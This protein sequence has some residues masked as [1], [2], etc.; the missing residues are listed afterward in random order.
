MI[1]F[2]KQCTGIRS[3]RTLFY[4]S[5]FCVA[6]SVMRIILTRTIFL[7]FLAWNLAL[8]FIPWCIAITLDI[9]KLRNKWYAVCL[10]MLWLLF[11]PNA[12]YILTD[13]I[14][15]KKT[16]SRYDWF[17]FILI[18]SYCFTGLFYGYVSLDFIERAIS[19]IFKMKHTLWFVCAVL[20]LSAYGIYLGR[21]LRWNSW[22]TIVR[23]YALFK[24]IFTHIRH[25]VEYKQVWSF[26][27]LMG[28]AL[29]LFYYAF[30]SFG[31]QDS[32]AAPECT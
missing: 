15:L 21:F 16:A 4:L 20:Y 2:I 13:M 29:I 12:P 17:T 32:A 25:P 8:A 5:L 14:H 28:T 10:I 9:I 7:S 18:L 11:F 3:T 30:K 1:T 27:F 19:R 26:S 23:P 24:D 22:D 31:T 6:L